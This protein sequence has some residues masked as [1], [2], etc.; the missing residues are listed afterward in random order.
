MK[1]LVLGKTFNTNRNLEFQVLIVVKTSYWNHDVGNGNVDSR[2]D[3]LFKS[4]FGQGK[5]CTLKL[6]IQQNQGVGIENVASS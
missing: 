4:W 5:C 1:R 3:I 6:N 2:S